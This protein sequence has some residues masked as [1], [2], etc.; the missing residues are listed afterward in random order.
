MTKFYNLVCIN[1]KPVRVLPAYS[2]MF[3]SYADTLIMYKTTRK[4]FIMKH[5]RVCSSAQSVYVK[6][7][8]C[9]PASILSGIWS[10]EQMTAAVLS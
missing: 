1:L 2:N 3:G 7:P 5:F 8:V 10:Q 4:P 9:E 6:P